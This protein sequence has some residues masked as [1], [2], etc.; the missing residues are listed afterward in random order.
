MLILSRAIRERPMKTRFSLDARGIFL[1]LSG[2][3]ILILVCLTGISVLVIWDSNTRLAL[4]HEQ[5]E[6]LADAQ[7]KLLNLLVIEQ[8]WLDLRTGAGDVAVEAE[9]D[10][11]DNLF[12]DMNAIMQEVN[13][14][15][16]ALRTSKSN[17]TNLSELTATGV[18]ILLV[19]FVILLLVAKERIVKPIWQLAGLLGRLAREDYRPARL[20]GLDAFIRPAFERYNRLVGRLERLENA[21][22]TRHQRME[23]QVRDAAR[24][25]VAQRAELARVERLAAVGEV[26]AVMAHEVRNPLAAIRSACR[27]LIEDAGEEDFRVRLGMIDDEVERLMSVVNR[28]LGNA[29]Y[30]P[31]KADRVDVTRLIMNLVNLMK[32][33][34]PDTV[35]LHVDVARDVTMLLPPNGLRQALLNLIRNSQE[36]LDGQTGDISI[37]IQGAE[38]ADGVEIRV[39]DS[40]S[41]FPQE[42]L[43]NGIHFFVSDKEGGT[44]L[45]LAMVE[46]YVRDQGGRMHIGN[47][48]E[49]GACVRINLPAR[50]EIGDRAA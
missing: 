43:T 34:M 26:V 5:A 2:L 16:E 13:A 40:G 37:T 32:Y 49:G 42:I 12:Q 24:T 21:H 33:Q 7:D 3:V 20:D 19:V 36:S 31:E 8:N 22:H 39:E 25:L 48:P 30:R 27:S 35:T 9:V 29:R 6:N 4:L 23:S 45:G 41:G 15:L 11:R 14:T 1:A 18:A 47:R 46:R 17:N 28:E 38:A 10:Q 44:G 50:A